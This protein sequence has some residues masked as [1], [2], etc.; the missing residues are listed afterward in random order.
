LDLFR[1]H[2]ESHDDFLFIF[3]YCEEAHPSGR[4]ATPEQRRAEAQRLAAHIGPN[5]TVL[6]DDFDKRSVQTLYSAGPMA[7]FVIDKTGII[8]AKRSPVD[9]SDLDNI[10]SPIAPAPPNHSL[11]RDALSSERSAPPP[12][13]HSSNQPRSSI[14]R[15]TVAITGI[16][17]ATG[18]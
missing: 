12:T 16:T 8:R 10:L 14:C 4:A 15:T 18:V 13:P 6:V 17:A 9:M 11:S 3:I 5:V 1:R 7:L 2:S